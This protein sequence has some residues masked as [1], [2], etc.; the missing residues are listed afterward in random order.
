MR[1]QTA[2][3]HCD[4]LDY[5]RTKPNAH[6][7]ERGGIGANL[8]DLEAGKVGLQ[9]MAI[10]TATEKGSTQHALQQ[11]KL[12]YDLLHDSGSGIVFPAGEINLNQL[13]EVRDLYAL[14]AIENAAGLCEEDQ[15]LEQAFLNL[16][17]ITA[18]SG[19]PLYI[20]FTHHAENR[21]GG[22][23]ATQI[24]LKDDGRE[25]LHHLHNKGIA[26]DFSH[27]SD[28]LADGIL[29]HIDLHGL[30]IPVLA[31]HSNFRSVFHHPRNLP[32]AIAQ[33]IIRRGGVIGMNFLRAFLHPTDANFLYRHMEHGLKLGGEGAI[34]FGADYFY[35]DSHPDQSRKPFFFPEQEDASHYPNIV[36]AM[37]N[38]FGEEAAEGMARLNA[39]QFINRVY[40]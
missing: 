7:H 14:T 9:V 37:I 26:V 36:Q 22:G 11:S 28:A 25:L 5:L 4:L 16:E 21:F 19:K 24:G 30:N 18:Q 8:S 31:S 13:E 1:F 2:D 29:N 39:L 15:P 20:G 17:K 23:N 12:F 32:D 27:T 34:C 33:E 3:L 35:V 10:Y 38:L 40:F 6:A